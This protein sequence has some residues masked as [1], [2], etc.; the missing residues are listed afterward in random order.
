MLTPTNKSTTDRFIQLF[1][2][3][4]ASCHEATG[5]L[6]VKTMKNSC[7]SGLAT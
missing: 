4:S 5:L 1:Y 7:L 3:Q 2:G 6:A